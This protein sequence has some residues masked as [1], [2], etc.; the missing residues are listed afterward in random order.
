LAAFQ[1][2]QQPAHRTETFDS[3][4]ILDQYSDQLRACSTQISH[5]TDF[6]SFP[7]IIS[8]LSIHSI[9]DQSLAAFQK[10]AHCTEIFVSD[11]ILD[12]YSDQPLGCS[13]QISHHTDFISVPSMISSLSIHSIQDQSLAAFQQY[14]QPARRTETFCN[15]YILDQHINVYTN[16][17]FACSSQNSDGSDFTSVPSMISSPSIHPVVAGT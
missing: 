7:S 8:S 13:A 10:P 2:Y 9:P 3:N 12:Q 17:P 15:N 5:D 6:I 11:N 1:K 14:Q 4:N 16:Q